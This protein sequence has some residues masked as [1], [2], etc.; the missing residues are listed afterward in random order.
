MSFT[1]LLISGS[2]TLQKLGHI[3]LPVRGAANLSFGLQEDFIGGFQ[4]SPDFYYYK[5]QSGSFRLIWQKQIPENLK[6]S[7]LKH[8]LPSGDIFLQL[9]H[10]EASLYDQQLRPIRTLHAPGGMIGLLHGGRYAVVTNH[11]SPGVPIKLSV[12]SASDLGSRHH[13]LDVPPEGEYDRDNHL[14][15]CG[16]EESGVAV[17][18]F[19]KPFVDIYDP[20]G[21]LY[22][23]YTCM[24]WYDIQ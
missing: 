5:Y 2:L 18:A 4:N 11:A 6:F 23:I 20:A 14:F 19:E 7:C 1:D 16:H 24:I 3:I 12:V 10:S 21:E 22:T 17:T 13:R 15:A 8:R 9:Y